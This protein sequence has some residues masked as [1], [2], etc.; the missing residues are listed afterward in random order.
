MSHAKYQV[1]GATN[2][3]P[4]LRPQR[5]GI[6]RFLQQERVVKT[7]TRI[8]SGMNA[9]PTVVAFATVCKALERTV[10]D[11]LWESQDDWFQLLKCFPPDVWEDRDNT[12]VS[13]HYFSIACRLPLFIP[14]I[15]AFPPQ[16]HASRVVP[17][18][19]IL[20]ENGPHERHAVAEVH[21]DPLL[22]NIEH[23]G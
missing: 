10:L 16:P 9:K 4:V 3:R 14:P 20:L 22:P 7:I 2:F 13:C 23:G 19:E 15:L 12:F 17:F 6:P 18:Q 11:V 5:H 8:L 1:V 21:I